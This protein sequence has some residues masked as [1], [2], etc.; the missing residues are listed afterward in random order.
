M[1]KPA[2]E[3]NS[4]IVPLFLFLLPYKK[5]MDVQLPLSSPIIKTIA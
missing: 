1:I 5:T 3:E 2:A 4:P